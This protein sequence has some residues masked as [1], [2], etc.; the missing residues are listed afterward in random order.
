MEL[1]LEGKVKDGRK[2]KL[3]R[4][5]DGRHYLQRVT[6]NNGEECYYERVSKADMPTWIEALKK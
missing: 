1:I 2:V 6:V 3:L 4:S 5:R